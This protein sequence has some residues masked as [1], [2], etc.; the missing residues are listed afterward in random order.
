M[1]RR[2]QQ[3]SGGRQKKSSSS[4]YEKYEQENSKLK[5]QMENYCGIWW[6]ASFPKSGNTWV[7]YMLELYYG[8]LDTTI[9]NMSIVSDDIRAVD[10]QAVTAKPRNQLGHEECILLRPA[11][12][13][14]KITMHRRLLPI[15]VKTHN[16]IDVH[17][18]YM[19]VPWLTFGAI[20]LVR[21]PRDVAISWAKHMGVTIDDAIDFMNN[22]EAALENSQSPS[23]LT[24]YLGTWSVHT[25]SW[26]ELQEKPVITVRYEDILEKPFESL[27]TFLRF[28]NQN[29]DLEIDESRARRAVTQASFPEMQRQEFEGHFREK[30]KGDAF[31]NKGTSG[32]WKETL[33]KSQVD[34]IKAHHKEM[35][36][37]FDY[38]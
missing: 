3:R 30:G 8:G 4:K 9:N 31:F 19:L 25:K 27:M 23:T 26:F 10:T 38:I 20:Y 28:I 32:H 22:H 12:L 36:E 1:K 24:S 33:S 21:D 13:H 11:M 18:D 14:H 7:R 29:Q 2:A 6:L 16:R 5:K 15:I 34:K 17:R 37:T 35:M